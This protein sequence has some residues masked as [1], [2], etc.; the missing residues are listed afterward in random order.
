MLT[1]S[2]YKVYVDKSFALRYAV[3]AGVI[4]DKN[5]V[6]ASQPPA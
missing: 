1:L 6:A 3:S 2:E 5:S 4:D